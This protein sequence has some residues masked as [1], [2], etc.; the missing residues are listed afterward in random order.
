MTGAPKVPPRQV[1]RVFCDSPSPRHRSGARTWLVTLERVVDRVGGKVLRDEWQVVQHNPSEAVRNPRRLGV[2]YLRGDEPADAGEDQMR[3]HLALRGIAMSARGGPPRTEDA[4]GR[5]KI[6]RTCPR[7]GDP[8]RVRIEDAA[9]V[10]VAVV[11]AG[12]DRI[13]SRVLRR[14]AGRV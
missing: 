7:C 8:L 5:A 1:V 6:D 10:L 4:A 11:E 9:P 12:Q 14:L 13:G 3:V 2:V